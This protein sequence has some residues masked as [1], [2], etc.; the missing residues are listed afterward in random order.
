[1]Y[2]SMDSELGEGRKKSRLILSEINKNGQNVETEKL[3][4]LIPSA[5]ESTGVQAPFY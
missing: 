4:Q 3:R 5:D 2:E 1:M